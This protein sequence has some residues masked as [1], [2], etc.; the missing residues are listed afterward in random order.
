MSYTGGVVCPGRPP[1]RLLAGRHGV[2]MATLPFS[3]RLAGVSFR[4]DVVRD[5]SVGDPVLLERDRGNERDPNAIAV[6]NRDR[7]QLGFVPAAVAARM[8]DL[9]GEQWVGRV[10]R[11]DPGATW[12]MEVRV[13]QEVSMDP[14]R[15]EPVVLSFPELEV[16]EDVSDAEVRYAYT[17]S[18]RFLGEVDE[19]GSEGRFVVAVTDAGVRVRYPAPVVKF[20]AR[21]P[22]IDEGVA[23]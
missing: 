21:R 13:M 19:A 16:E 6:F 15:V 14:G 5:S 20:S 9:P 3:T 2:G 22:A 10:S 18:G 23:A 7:R 12:G 8:K 11:V 17:V 1:F 4:Q